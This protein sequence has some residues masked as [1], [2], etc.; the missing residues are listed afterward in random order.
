VCVC[1]CVARAIIGYIP[2]W[3]SL[4]SIVVC[5][6]TPRTATTG[7]EGQSGYMDY[8]V[9]EF[10]YIVNIRVHVRVVLCVSY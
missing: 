6:H 8:Q 2:H 9:N 3:W 10:I 4:V 7:M 1:V 5:S